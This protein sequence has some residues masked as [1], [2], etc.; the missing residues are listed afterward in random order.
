[1]QGGLGTCGFFPLNLGS[2]VMSNH[3]SKE[4]RETKGI[5]ITAVTPLI[6]HPHP[7]QQW[8]TMYG[9]IICILLLMISL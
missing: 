7:Q 6:S 3:R 8:P 4:S 9:I 1:M 5:R 2:V